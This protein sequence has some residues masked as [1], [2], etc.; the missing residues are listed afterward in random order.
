[1]VVFIILIITICYKLIFG[2]KVL[3]KMIKLECHIQLGQVRDPP[4]ESDNKQFQ[5]I[6]LQFVNKKL[7]AK[8]TKVVSEATIAPRFPPRTF[9]TLT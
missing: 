8:T 9:G 1:M 6:L 3:Y 7:T 5:E 2:L 4:F